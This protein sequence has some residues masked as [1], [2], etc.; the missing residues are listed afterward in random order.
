MVQALDEKTGGGSSSTLLALTADDNDKE[1]VHR[2]VV[3][4]LPSKVS[5]HNHPMAVHTLTRMVGTAA[6][7]EHSRLVVLTDDF[8]IGPLALAIAKAFPLFSK[9]TTTTN[10]KAKN[11]HIT[12][13]QSDGSVVK[14]SAA[15]YAAQVA[16][17][18]VRLAAR[19]VDSHP[20]LL[21]TAQFSKEIK[22]LVQEHK[23]V[24]M[25]EII[26]KDLAAQGYG[27]LYGVGKGA[28]C[29]PRMVILEYDGVAAAKEG[30]G[31][32]SSV[33]DK[34]ETIA[35][36]GKGIVYDTGGLSLKVRGH[37][38][39]ALTSWTLLNFC[40]HPHSLFVLLLLATIRVEPGCPE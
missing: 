9:K 19:L 24:Q 8:P 36:V 12:F 32:S 23:H 39:P 2:L 22:E 30:G 29:P 3:A 34:T 21:T 35:L 14:D 27:G 10:G 5:R 13:V 1:N 38:Q 31:A 15:L 33:P 28:N 11:L 25:K 4:G 18:G 17:K 6:K 7:G 37:K 20:E 40:H 26:G 16:A